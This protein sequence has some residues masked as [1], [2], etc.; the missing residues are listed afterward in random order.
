MTNQIGIYDHSTGENIVREMTAEEIAT[1]K[2]EATERAAAKAA[3]LAEKETAKTALLSSLG[4]TEAQAVTLGLLPSGSN[5]IPVEHFDG[6]S[7][8]K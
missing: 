1:Y 2:A 6:D 3:I 8:S 7:A 4:I 5:P